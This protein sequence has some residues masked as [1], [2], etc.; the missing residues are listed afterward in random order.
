MKHRAGRPGRGIVAVAFMGLCALFASACYPGFVIGVAGTGAEG[1]GGDAGPAISATFASPGALAYDPSGAYF[2]LDTS[3]CV[4]RKVDPAGTVSSV[5]GTGTCGNGGLGSGT[6]TEMMI[7]PIAGM[8]NIALDA[9]GNL[10]LADSGNARLRMITPGGTMSTV[11]VANYADVLPFGSAFTQVAVSSAGTLYAG[12]SPSGLWRMNADGSWTRA[13]GAA[14]TAV[15][16][17]PSGGVVFLAAGTRVYRLA[18][19]STTPEFVATLPTTAFALAVA[20]T[21]QIYA[22]LETH[23][24]RIESDGRWSNVAGNGRYDLDGGVQMGDARELRLSPLGVAVTENNGILLSSGH[25]VY[26]LDRPAEAAA[27]CDI[28][29]FVPG[30]DLS[31]QDLSGADLAR[32]DLSGANL[33]GT[34]LAGAV[35]DRVRSGG[36]TGTPASLPAGWVLASG[37]L[38]GPGADMSTAYV[39]GG[40]FTGV[41][42]AGVDLTGAMIGGADLAGADLSGA[43]LHDPVYALV[44]SDLTGADLSELNLSTTILAGSTLVDTDIDGTNLGSATLTGV[45]SG[46]LIGTPAALPEG[47]TL[48]DGTLL[49]PGP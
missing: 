22:G 25:V 32:C 18:E 23:L 8:S 14:V 12:T 29:R 20:A 46:G 3:A 30:V 17:D 2:V 49:P 27:S 47:W 45:T 16:A 10:F 43:V 7:D 6:A 39:D 37:W 42:F 40:D 13:V 35:L 19:G 1:S 38:I 11:E 44:N 4:I 9:A 31:G 24:L 33:E 28:S 15:A 34:E 41:D 36:V 26:R 48:L 5:A 21:G